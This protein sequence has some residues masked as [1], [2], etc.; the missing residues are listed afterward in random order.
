[1]IYKLAWERQAVEKALER[2]LLPNKF[3]RL[4]TIQTSLSI[5]R[6]VTHNILITAILKLWK[7]S[8]LPHSA[9]ATQSVVK[10]GLGEF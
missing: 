7:L 8:V 1:M 9:N 4:L 3:I 2:N 10:G 5:I 6:T